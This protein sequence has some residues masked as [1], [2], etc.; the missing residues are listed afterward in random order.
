[1]KKLSFIFAMVFAVT[2]AMAQNTAKTAQ[3]GNHNGANVAQSDGINNDAAVTQNGD[4][5]NGV[6]TEKGTSNTGVVDQLKGNQNNGNVDQTGN[7]NEAYLTQGMVENYYDAP[8]NIS[9]AMAASNNTGVIVQKGGNKN[10]TELVQV[11]NVNAANISQDGSKNIAYGYQ[12]WPFGFW[13]ETYATSH[14]SSSN[15][16]ISITQLQNSNEGAVWQYGGDKNSATIGQNGL[17]NVARISQG[18]IYNDEAYNFSHPVYNVN[19]NTASISQVGD[20]NTG[21]LFQLGDGNSFSL[22]QTGNHN[23]VGLAAG[24]LLEARD[25]YFQQDGNGNNFYGTQDGGATLKNTSGQTG[26]SNLI[27]MSQ[28]ANDM[29]EIIQ[30]GDLNQAFLTQGGGGQD[31]TITQMGSVNTSVVNQHN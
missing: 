11:G 24:G 8:Y 6:I 30:D 15:S 7:L 4:Y 23:T 19:N 10:Y 28:G 20:N 1:M 29:A 25:G 5:N 3:T 12:G 31:A 14:L 16:N 18:F 26:N 13:G 21:K 2:F 17:S 27:N 22:T 9:S